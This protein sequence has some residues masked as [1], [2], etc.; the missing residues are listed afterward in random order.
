MKILICDDSMLVRKKLSVSL[1]K[2]GITEIVEAS[3]GELA[4]D[5]YKKE[6][7]DLTL[8][9]IVMPKINGVDALKAILAADPKARVVMASSVG[10][11]ENLREAI[12]AGAYDFLQK[13]I[14]EDQLKEL[15]E[16]ASK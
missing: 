11:Q 9:D 12:M 10:T 15:I 3:D 14:S 8:M 13:P 6:S 16:K 2:L 1:K 5:M 4:V 7:P